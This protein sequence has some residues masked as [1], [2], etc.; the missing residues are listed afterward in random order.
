M[1][2]RFIL[3]SNY[4]RIR[5]RLDMASL[6]EGET[7]VPSLNTAPDDEHLCTYLHLK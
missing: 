4:K 2:D 1:F 5:T 6:P 7:Y 3:A